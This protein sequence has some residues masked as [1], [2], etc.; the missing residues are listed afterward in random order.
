MGEDAGDGAGKQARGSDR[1]VKGCRRGW[2]GLIY[3]FT[4]THGFWVEGELG[5]VRVKEGR[6]GKRLLQES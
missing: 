4:G 3:T 6:S 2:H 5:K 1:A